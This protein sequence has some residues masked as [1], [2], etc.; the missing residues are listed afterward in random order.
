MLTALL[1]G[2]LEANVSALTL[3]RGAPGIHGITLY[4]SLNVLKKKK[5]PKQRVSSSVEDKLPNGGSKELLIRFL[6]FCGIISSTALLGVTSQEHHP[7]LSP[8]DSFKSKK[9]GPHHFLL[10]AVSWEVL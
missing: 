5:K 3:N 4:N 2:R 10:C 7:I 1:K 8:E 9:P 6:L